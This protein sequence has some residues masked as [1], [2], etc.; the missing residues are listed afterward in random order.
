MYK[1][2]VPWEREKS[3]V[4]LVLIEWLSTFTVH[5]DLV[6]VESWSYSYLVLAL[7]LVC[8]FDYDDSYFMECIYLMVY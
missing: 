5:L 8:T 6:V 4:L 2:Y 1:N 7:S 3:L